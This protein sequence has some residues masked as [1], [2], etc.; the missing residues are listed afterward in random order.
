MRPA[1]SDAET[2]I[3]AL[4]LRVPSDP[5][6]CPFGML[7]SLVVHP[8]QEDLNHA[9]MWAMQTLLF[10][11]RGHYTSGPLETVEQA[12]ITAEAQANRFCREAEAEC[13]L[14]SMPGDLIDRLTVKVLNW[15]VANWT[16]R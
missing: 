10:A 13:G 4:R 5:A 1:G 15:V 6:S 8:N 14:N 3:R 9:R 16:V 12:T 11:M 7:R 2:S